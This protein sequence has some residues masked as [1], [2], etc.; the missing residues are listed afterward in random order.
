MSTPETRQS[1]PK[2]KGV[3]KKE[4]VDECKRFVMTIGHP[5]SLKRKKCYLYFKDNQKKK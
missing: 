2:K 5:L 3:K 1:H 4:S